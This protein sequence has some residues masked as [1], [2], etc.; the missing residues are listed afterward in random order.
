MHGGWHMVQVSK[1]L[2]THAEIMKWL[3]ANQACFQECFATPRDCSLR[4]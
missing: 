3:C 4:L 2:P 1:A